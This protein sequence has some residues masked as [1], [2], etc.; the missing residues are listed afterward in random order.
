[1]IITDHGACNTDLIDKYL[2]D[3]PTQ[4]LARAM[5]MLVHIT[6]E[7]ITVVTADG[8]ARNTPHQMLAD[9]LTFGHKQKGKYVW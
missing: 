3:H 7:D 6:L 2:L 9:S 1:M 5:N 8:S 4:N